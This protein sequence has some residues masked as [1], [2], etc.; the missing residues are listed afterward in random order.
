MQRNRRPA[1]RTYDSVIIAVSDV[2]QYLKSP[3]TWKVRLS[4]SLARSSRVSSFL[5]TSLAALILRTWREIQRT[6]E[7]GRVAS[8]PLD[9]A[10]ER[11]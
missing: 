10:H 3:M 5:S 7:E 1:Q 4:A 6:G 11:G 8:S 2:S 9:A